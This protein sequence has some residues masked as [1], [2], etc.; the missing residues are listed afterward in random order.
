MTPEEVVQKQLE[1]YNACDLAAFAATYA[2]NVRI[3]DE[4]GKLICDGVAE[5]QCRRFMPAKGEGQI[6]GQ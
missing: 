3:T 4:T 5:P 6:T 2:D 1:A